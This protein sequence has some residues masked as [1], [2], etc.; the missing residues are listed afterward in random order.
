MSFLNNKCIS[1]SDYEKAAFMANEA[2]EEMLS[3]LEWM[4]L[5]PKIILDV[6][7]GVGQSASSLQKRYPEAS[8][9]GLDYALPMLQHVQ[10]NQSPLH[11][12]C[13]V[14]EALPFAAQS[15]D[16]MVANFFLPWQ[17]DVKSVLQEWRR[18]LVPNGLLLITTLG[19]NTLQEYR[20]VL[21]SEHIPNLVDMHDVGD[22]LVQAGFVE[23]VLDVAHYQ[24][25]YR[26]RNK[27]LHELKASG[28]WFPDEEAARQ[29]DELLP[30]ADGRW[31]LTYEVIYAHAFA[32]MEKNAYAVEEGMVK[33]PLA[34]LRQQL[35]RGNQ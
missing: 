28:F 1:P 25:A 13:A 21:A 23:P 16:L 22:A 31:S 8:I 32:P 2:S 33:F 17:Q 30:E 10:Q 27:L 5:A 29:G 20:N 14:A 26:E 24:V 9:I 6:G 35:N 19:L 7:C 12:C 11:C 3:R 18:V 4:T 34:Q 15:V